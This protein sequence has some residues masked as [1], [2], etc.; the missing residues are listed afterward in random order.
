MCLILIKNRSMAIILG[1]MLFDYETVHDCPAADVHEEKQTSSFTDFDRP[2]K[3]GGEE[4]EG[5]V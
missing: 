3:S 5:E 1:L 4:R 2:H